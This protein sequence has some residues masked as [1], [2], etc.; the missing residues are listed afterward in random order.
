MDKLRTE[1]NILLKR[2]QKGEAYLDNENI[3][4][5]KREKWIPEFLKIARR[6]GEIIRKLGN[7][8]AYEILNGFGEDRSE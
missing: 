6:M 2:A 4:V 5:Q 7:V 3:D 8:T 1:Y